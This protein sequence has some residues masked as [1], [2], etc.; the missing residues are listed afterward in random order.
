MKISL[1]IVKK[2]LYI[3]LWNHINYYLDFYW[4]DGDWGLGIGDWGFGVGAQPPTPIPQ[5][6]SPIPHD[7]FIF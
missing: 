4:R 7:I 3:F 2:Y 5:P 6:Q 1:F